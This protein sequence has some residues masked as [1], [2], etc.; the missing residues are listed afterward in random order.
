MPRDRHESKSM[1]KY[2]QIENLRERAE[3]IDFVFDRL[4]LFNDIDRIFIIKY[5]QRSILT[6]TT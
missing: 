4:L 6:C 1:Q 5:H 3:L 2:S